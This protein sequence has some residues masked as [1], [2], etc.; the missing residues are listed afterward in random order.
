L[1]YRY[2]STNTDRR[3]ASCPPHLPAA[4]CLAVLPR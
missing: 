3:R 1:L 2:Q 4:A